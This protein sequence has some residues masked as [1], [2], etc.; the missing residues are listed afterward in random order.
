[1]RFALVALCLCSNLCADDWPQWLGPKRDGVWREKNLLSRFPKEGLKP[2]WRTP[3]GQG[4]AGPAVVGDRVFVM[5]R[6][7]LPNA[8]GKEVIERL[9]CLSATTGKIIWKKEWTADYR[10]VFYGTG[11]RTTPVIADGMVHVL[12]A[13]GDLYCFATKDGKEI[14]HRSLAKDYQAKPPV[15]GWSASPIL[16]GEL[17]Y[18]LVGGKGS[19][20]VAFDRKTGKEKWK[21]LTSEEIGYAPPIFATVEGKKQLIVWLS[22]LIAGLDP[23]TG[24]KHWSHPYPED[25]KPTRP[26]VSIGTPRFKGGMLFV[27]AFYQGSMMLKIEKNKPSIVWQSRSKNPQKPDT[28]NVV[29]GT[30]MFKDGV[31]YAVGGFGHLRC[32]DSKTGKQKWTTFQATGGKKAFLATAFLIEHEDRVFI[33]NDQGD[34]ILAKLTPKGYEQ[35]DRAHLIDTSQTARGRQVVW[36]HPAFARGCVFVRND[37]EILC[38]P[39]KK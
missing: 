3:I 11:P 27:S 18:C 20:I 12:G 25:G 1:M 17:L 37:K 9:L 38:V 22:D 26:A 4:Y 15:W 13:K 30:P 23:L 32:L 14:W 36:C 34:L 35:L 5:D 28:V 8:K 39:L 10:R 24:K 21:A 33:F 7:N 19:G 31:I 2:L 29:M 6:Q 16:E